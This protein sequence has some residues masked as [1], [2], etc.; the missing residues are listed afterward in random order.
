MYG[1][2]PVDIEWGRK[3]LRR[4]T[5]KPDWDLDLDPTGALRADYVAPN[6]SDNM[7]GCPLG[8][9]LRVAHRRPLHPAAFLRMEETEFL[10]AVREA[11]GEIEEHERDEFFKID[12][13]ARW[14]PH[15]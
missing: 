5:Y 10:R 3:I 9:P 2:A 7:A 4:V 8:M 15:V 11:L 13:E 14:H 12:G 6:A 1:P